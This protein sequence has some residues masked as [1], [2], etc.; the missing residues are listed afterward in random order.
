MPEIFEVES[1]SRRGQHL[2]NL[3]ILDGGKG[4][5]N[6][7]NELIRHYPH[8]AAL[9]KTVQFAALGK[10][11][12]RKTATIGKKSKKSEQ[13]VGEKLYLWR[14]GAIESYDLVYDEADRLLIKL[15][16]EAHRFANYYRKQQEKLAFN[17][18]KKQATR[19]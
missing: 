5:L 16:N 12:A 3:F 9:T 17:T 2:P 8:L 11:E 6:I 7:L 18:A 10:G 14:E 1:G 19:S 4:Q 15:R 13:M